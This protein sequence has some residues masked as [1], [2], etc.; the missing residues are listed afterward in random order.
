MLCY[1]FFLSI[2]FKSIKFSSL[3]T[4]TVYFVPIQFDGPLPPILNALEVT[5]AAGMPRL[6]LEVAQHL[7]ENTVRTISME[8]HLQPWINIISCILIYLFT[9]PSS[10]FW[11]C[12]YHSPSLALSSPPSSS[13]S[14]SIFLFLSLPLPRVGLFY[15][16]SSPIHLLAL[17]LSLSLSLTFS[18][19]LLPFFFVGHGRS[20]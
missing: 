6:V 4:L 11:K 15:L 14:P 3:W 8:V 1:P 5:V 10:F 17:F 2:S 9:L 13:R 12:S 16:P 20:C 7:G 19:S 18:S